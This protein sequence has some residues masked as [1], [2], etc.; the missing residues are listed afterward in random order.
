MSPLRLSYRRR[1]WSHSFVESWCNEFFISE[2]TKARNLNKVFPFLYT[3]QLAL[4]DISFRQ[5]FPSGHPSDPYEMWL[6]FPDTTLFLFTCL[7]STIV[8]EVSSP[9]PCAYVV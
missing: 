5:S 3:V 1:T 4:S 9:S 6:K 2:S 7:L 8:L